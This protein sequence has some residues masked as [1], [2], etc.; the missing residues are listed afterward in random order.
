MSTI[1]AP[2]KPEL[3][4]VPIR[5]I[6]TCELARS[7]ENDQLY[8]PVD[9]AE[10]SIIALAESIAE[11]GVQEPL[12]VTGDHY[13]ASGHRRLVAA[14]L[15]GLQYV[16]CRVLDFDKDE[17]HDQFMRLLRECN[18]QRVK[19][20]AETLPMTIGRGYCS[21]RPRYD[22]AQRY[23][24]SGKDH[25]ILLMLADFDPDGEEIAHSFARSMRDDFDIARVEP[26]KVALTARHVSELDLPPACKA[27]TKSSQYN[28]FNEKHG[29]KVWEL[30]AVSPAVLQKILTKAIDSVIDIEA[31]NHEIDREKEDAQELEGVRQ[32]VID[33]LRE[34]EE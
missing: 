34:Y 32:V 27:K 24:R 21:L 20:F 25:L 11:I 7:P 17:N 29:N 4:L 28:K 1:I 10:P 2:T 14:D 23:L 3:G 6:P 8:K 9:P 33:V 12:I 26:V 19:T 31:F 13:V 22:I 5:E 30:E 18:R 16:P 15:A